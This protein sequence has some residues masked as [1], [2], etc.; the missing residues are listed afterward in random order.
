MSKTDPKKE[1][2]PLTAALVKPIDL[3]V[4]AASTGGPAALASLL[5]CEALRETLRKPVVIVQHMPAIFTKY[6]ASRL[7]EET[8][9]DIAEATEGETLK[10]G[11]IRIAP[12]GNHLVVNR[13]LKEY[14]T[15]I[16]RADL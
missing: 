12:G 14:T 5:R 6:L 2:T 10:P 9:L 7:A 4:I 15:S 16:N 13:T 3:V 11:M 8:G 1:G